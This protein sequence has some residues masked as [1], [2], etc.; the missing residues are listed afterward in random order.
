MSGPTFFL[1]FSLDTAISV[2]CLN[3]ENAEAKIDLN[4][5]KSF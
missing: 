1:V 5:S 4:A 2:T 3:I